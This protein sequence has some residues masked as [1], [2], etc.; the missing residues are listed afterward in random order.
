MPL[1][2]SRRQLGLEETSAAGREP[3]TFYCLCVLIMPVCDSR[4]FTCRA[5]DKRGEGRA[6]R[7]EEGGSKHKDSRP[8]SSSRRDGATTRPS[9]SSSLTAFC[10]LSASQ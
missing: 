8:A 7:R 5:R 4:Q 3:E 6:S 10:G 1:G 9:G 2:R